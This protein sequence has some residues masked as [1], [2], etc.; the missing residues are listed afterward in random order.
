MSRSVFYL[1]L[2]VCATVPQTFVAAVEIDE[3]TG[4]RTSRRREADSPRSPDVRGGAG[5]EKRGSE[6]RRL[7]FLSD[8][9]ITLVVYSGIKQ[10]AFVWHAYTR[11]CSTHV[12]QAGA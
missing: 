6:V 8:F 1:S 7:C 3:D 4:S 10:K 11:Y 9:C 2:S 12:C 5:G